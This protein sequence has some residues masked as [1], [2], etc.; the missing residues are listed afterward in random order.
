MISVVSVES[1]F[2]AEDPAVLRRNINYAILAVKDCSLNY[3]EAP[4]ASHLLHTQ[5]V[6]AGRHD[7]I[8]DSVP[9]PFDLSRKEV[10]QNT[11]AIRQRCDKIV[12]YVD[13]GKSAGMLD[14]VGLA[15]RCG[16]PVEERRLPP[17]MMAELAE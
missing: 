5:C 8:S 9:D 10:I 4:Y 6:R 16:I 2:H 12:L 3:G 15:Q 13:F 17:E 11:M 1:P 7:Y 14:A